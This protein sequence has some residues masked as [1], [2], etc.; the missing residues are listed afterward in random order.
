M[1]DKITRCKQILRA[2]RSEISVAFEILVKKLQVEDNEAYEE[3]MK[4]NN[5]KFCETLV[6]TILVSLPFII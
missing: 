4:M 2:L 3:I 5:E 1:V 6:A